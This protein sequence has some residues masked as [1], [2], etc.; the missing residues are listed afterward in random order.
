ML[1]VEFMPRAFWFFFLWGISAHFSHQK[2]SSSEA[3][4]GNLVSCSFEIY[5]QARNASVGELWNLQLVPPAFLMMMVNKPRHWQANKS[6]NLWSQ[7]SEKADLLGLSFFCREL[8]YFFFF[9]TLKLYK[10]NWHGCY[11]ND[12]IIF[13]SFY[14][15]RMNCASI[16]WSH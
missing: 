9:L 3:R 12:H 13:R 14:G 16:S 4:L 6:L 15:C 8:I 11:F 7:L 1:L 5:P 10:T 2:S